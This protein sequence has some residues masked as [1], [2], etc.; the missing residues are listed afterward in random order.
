MAQ[1]PDTIPIGSRDMGSRGY[2]CCSRGS[3]HQ[4]SQGN[5]GLLAAL[6]NFLLGICLKFLCLIQMVQSLD[7][8]SNKSF[9][10]SLSI[11]FIGI[12]HIF[13]NRP[14]RSWWIKSMHPPW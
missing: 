9:G 13:L 6:V 14:N 10:T 4:S 5:T 2:M 1:A 7:T 8:I 11:Y 3:R 12:R